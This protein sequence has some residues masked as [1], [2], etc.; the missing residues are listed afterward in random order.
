MDAKVLSE[1]YFKNRNLND[2]KRVKSFESE[3]VFVKSEISKGNLLDIGCSTGEMIEVFEWDGECFGMEISDHAKEI[4]KKKGIRFDMD[5][6]NATDFFDVI[7]FRGTIQHVYTPFL[8]LQKAFDALNPGGKV[9]FL[10]T[11]N[12]NSIYFKI[13]NTL[14]FLD[15]PTICYFIPHDKWLIQTMENFGFKLIKKRYPYL[16]SPYSSFIKDHI[17]FVLKLFGFKLE[18]PFWRNS[19][20]LIFIKPN[21]I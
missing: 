16:K 6:F 3:S 5:L 2:I 15:Y 11:P 19:M 8:Y 9:V 4:A 18:F 1:D 21:K 10:A 12:T 14:P 20:D 13:W 17:K 7:I